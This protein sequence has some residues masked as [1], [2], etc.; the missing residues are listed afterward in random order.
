MKR[1]V[2]N[3][4]KAYVNQSAR[5]EHRRHAPEDVPEDSPEDGRAEQEPWT[6]VYEP[7]RT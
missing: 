5:G 6:S 3:V 7:F 4:A 2:Y 1:M